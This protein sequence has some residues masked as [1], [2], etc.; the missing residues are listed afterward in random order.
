VSQLDVRVAY[1]GT[2]AMLMYYADLPYALEPHVGLTDHEVARLPPPSGPRVG[3]GQ[4][5]DVTYLRQREIDLVFSFRL[6]QPITDITRLTFPDGLQARI[7]TWR[8]EVMSGVRACGARSM[9]FERFLDQWVAQ[10]DQADD[11]EVDKAW[12]N[13]SAFYFDHNDDPV[14]ENAFRRRLGLPPRAEGDDR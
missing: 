8:S 1:Y 10:L 14:R 9:D 6:Q 2:Q 11:A 7:L 3:H 4:K 5:T 13:F 12:R